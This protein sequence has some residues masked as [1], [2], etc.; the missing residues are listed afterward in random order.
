MSES[1][2]TERRSEGQIVRVR[3]DKREKKLRNGLEDL[4]LPAIFQGMPK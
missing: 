4:R 1:V 2:G 3:M